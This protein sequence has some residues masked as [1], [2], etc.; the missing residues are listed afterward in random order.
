MKIFI[1][2]SAPKFV[3]GDRVA[4]EFDKNDWAC[5]TI[6]KVTPTGY[7]IDFDYGESKLLKTTD[8]RFL[9]VGKKK[10]KKGL[11]LAEVKALK[12]EPAAKKEAP[13]KAKTAKE[14]AT[15][16]VAAKPAPAPAKAKPVA[17]APAKAV[18]AKEPFAKESKPA[19][20]PRR[21]IGSVVKSKWGNVVILSKKLGR[22]YVEYKWSRIDQPGTG[23][24]KTPNFDENSMFLNYPYV[25][26]ATDVEMNGGHAQVRDY[27]EKKAQRHSDALDSIQKQDIK[28]GDIVRVEYSNGVKKEAVLEVDYRA[29]KLAIV[30]QQSGAASI[31]TKRRMLPVKI[32]TKLIDGG[33]KFDPNNEIYAKNGIFI[34]QFYKDGGRVA[35]RRPKFRW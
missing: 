14:P 31:Y 15:K 9:P 12:P 6:L 28:P 5:G 22:K 26:D 3:A 27:Q 23:W 25:R 19:A 2:L 1:S 21:F 4:V 35:E 18:P 29:G 16:K 11:T 34:P 10:Y 7:R 24:M 30:R 32:C 20:K 8:A 17:K 13:V 33:G